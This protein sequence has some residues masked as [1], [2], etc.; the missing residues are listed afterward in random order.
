MRKRVGGSPERQPYGDVVDARD[1]ERALFGGRVGA[2]V[3]TGRV[4]AGEVPR[5]A[6]QEVLVQRV[7][8]RREMDLD[9][10]AD[11]E[12][13]VGEHPG[14]TLPSEQARIAVEPE[15]QATRCASAHGGR[16]ED[17]GRDQCR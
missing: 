13:C 17:S 12:R 8:S 7:G 3:V 1:G 9:W 5:C 10:R 2:A 6:W 15:R 4:G 16:S 11:V 14:V